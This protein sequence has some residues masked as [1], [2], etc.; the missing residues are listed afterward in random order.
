MV[1]LQGQAL[2][3]EAVLEESTALLTRMHPEEDRRHLC[4][5]PLVKAVESCCCDLG[6]GIF[7]L[8]HVHEQLCSSDGGW[9]HNHKKTSKMLEKLHTMVYLSLALPLPSW[10]SPGTAVWLDAENTRRLLPRAPVHWLDISGAAR[11]QGWNNRPMLI[12]WLISV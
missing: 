6:S 2:L 12:R 11:M 7:T 9:K 5:S 3:L 1:T 4:R 10:M 8:Q